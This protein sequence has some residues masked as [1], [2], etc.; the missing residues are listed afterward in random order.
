MQSLARGKASKK[1]LANVAKFNR[2]LR[3]AMIGA[4]VAERSYRESAVPDYP[5]LAA[6][7]GEWIMATRYGVFRI[8]THGDSMVIYG[9]FDR[10]DLHPPGNPFSG[11]YNTINSD[12]SDP[13]TCVAEFL[14][15]IAELRCV[16]PSL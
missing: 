1:Q 12:D 14:E 6:G 5:S 10:Q 4:G 13:A 15:T 2:L 16:A 3:V 8:S 9:R 11:K 7:A